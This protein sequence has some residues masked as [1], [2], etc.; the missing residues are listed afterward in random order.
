MLQIA[1]VAVVTW[2]FA[3]ADG[4]QAP[5]NFDVWFAIFFTALLSTVF[6]FWVQTW[7]QTIIEPSRVALLITSEVVF[8][9]L[10]AVGVGQEPLTLTMVVGGSIMVVAMLLVEWP[11]SK[12]KPVK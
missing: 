3:L 7:A 12:A 1:F 11:S 9:A 6:A 4:Y 8:T 2:V 5:P 10:I